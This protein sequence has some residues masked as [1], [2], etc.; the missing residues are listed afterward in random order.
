MVKAIV[1]HEAGGP[2]VLRYENVTVGK[3]GPGE[4]RLRQTTAGVNFVDI[5]YRVGKYNYSARPGA[6]GSYIPGL[7]G[8]G[9]VQ[10][11]GPG[12]T[13]L[14]VGDRVCYGNGPIGGYAEER[15]IPAHNVVKCPPQLK[16]EQIAGMMLRGLT[17]WYLLRSLYTLK[18]GETVLLHAAAG[19]IG[20]IFC[21]WARHIGATVIGTVGSE[22]KA[23]LARN[24]GCA[25]T[26]L[27]KTGDWVAKIR[28]ITSGK[29]VSVVYDGV[30]KDTFMGSLDCLRPRGL[31]VNFGNASGAAPAIE[32][33]VL[34]AKGS[35]FLTRPRLAE[36]VEAR[37]DY[38][39][40]CNE[41]FELVVK[42]TIKI[43][44]GQSYGLA[45]AA[46]AHSDLEARAT[47]GST[48][49]VM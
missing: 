33:N 5:Y 44:V 13:D 38:V 36:Y 16:D 37:E 2:E 10:E 25:H 39:R 41:L 23:V 1:V 9:T 34:A 48:I 49:L 43:D 19:G 4:V 27:Y 8:V 42:G 21:Q 3:P 30:G 45:Q 26:I 12:V 20:L 11:L 31:L 35:L 15:L 18:A 17:V 24:A 22:E 14:K 32:P 29:G 40:A 28:E 7:E 46:H 6:N 47:T